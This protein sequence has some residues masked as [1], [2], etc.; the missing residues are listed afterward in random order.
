MDVFSSR[1]GGVLVVPME[2][3]APA[4]LTIEGYAGPDAGYN[5]VRAIVTNIGINEN[6]AVQISHAL[7]DSVYYYTFGDRVGDFEF[8][9]ILF[10][11][12]CDGPNGFTETYKYWRKNRAGGRD[13]PIT[14]S[15]GTE[16]VVRGLLMNMRLVLDNPELSFGRF[17]FAMKHFPDVTEMH[18]GDGDTDAEDE[19]I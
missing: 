7:S 5:T 12:T 13:T 10:V 11:N 19:F 9:G 17:S 2:Q 18:L 16:F 8:S 1:L 6:A 4:A 15:F 3:A 14:V